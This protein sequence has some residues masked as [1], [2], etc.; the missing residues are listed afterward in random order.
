M[1]DFSTACLR[2]ST[3]RLHYKATT[4]AADFLPRHMDRMIASLKDQGFTSGDIILYHARN[5]PF[6]FPLLM[7]ADA[8]CG[9]VLC[10]DDRLTANEVAA[11]E[12]RLQSQ[13]HFCYDDASLTYTF[14][15]KNLTR[16]TGS[17]HESI[18]RFGGGI[19]NLTSGTT[20]PASLIF[21]SFD[22]T[23]ESLHFPSREQN[24]TAESGTLSYL[25]YTHS[26]GLLLQTLPTLI[27][28]GL[29]EIEHLSNLKNFLAQ[30]SNCTHLILVP[31]VYQ[32]LKKTNRLLQLHSGAQKT[33]ITGSS[34][35]PPE[36]FLDLSHIHDVINVYGLTE[37]TPF[38]FYTRSFI[39]DISAGSLAG[40]IIATHDYDIT[41]DNEIMVKGPLLGHIYDS[42]AEQLVPLGNSQNSFFYRT[43]DLG[44][45]TDQG[46]VLN[47][48]KKMIINY[49]GFKFSPSEV[50]TIAL[51]Y[52]NV[53]KCAVKKEVAENGDEY[54][55]IFIELFSKEP[56]AAAFIPAFETYLRRHLSVEKMPRKIQ[57]CDDLPETL[58]GKNDYGKIR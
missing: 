43:G 19:L 45:R 42:D 34:T 40:R 6:L 13:F 48:R 25:S 16:Q 11:V 36:M 22:Q 2:H 38:L 37:I 28:G 32:S 26:G 53:L 44:H 5:N 27:N 21:H 57:I 10:L 55:V 20:G 15:P 46:L 52:P 58:I 17:L 9:A 30:L 41:A 35:V 54:P 1:S 47:G 33:V 50:E 29:I 24:I 49:R 3:T 39:P 14:A 31:S 51:Q 23:L 12:Q 4:Y 7:A 18:S 56:D 8:L